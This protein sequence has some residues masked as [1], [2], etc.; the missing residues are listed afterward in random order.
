LRGW[1]IPEEIRPA[2]DDAFEHDGREQKWPLDP[3]TD[4]EVRAGAAANLSL[5]LS[6]LVMVMMMVMVMVM[7]CW[8]AGRLTS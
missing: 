7:V 5:S 1:S 8:L 6:F 4:R 2:W 3:I